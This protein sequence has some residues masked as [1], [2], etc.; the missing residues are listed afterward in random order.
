MFWKQFFPLEKK[1]LGDSFSEYRGNWELLEIS[2]RGHTWNQSDHLWSGLLEQCDRG[3]Y[4]APEWQDL[5]DY[6]LPA[7]HGPRVY[8]RS[9]WLS[10]EE[11][12][13]RNIHLIGNLRIMG[14]NL[15]Q[16]GLSDGTHGTEQ[17][18]INIQ[19]INLKL[20]YIEEWNK[21]PWTKFLW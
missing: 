4:L 15:H 10:A 11:K 21:T 3:L 20:S 8:C 2:D 13:R 16:Q 1:L 19:K 6:K 5:W 17:S 9:R 7:I 12:N 14:D 18:V